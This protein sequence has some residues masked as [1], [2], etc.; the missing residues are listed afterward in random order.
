MR[1][2]G[3][4]TMSGRESRLTPVVGRD[5][6]LSAVVVLSAVVMIGRVASITSAVILTGFTATKMS[7]S[8]GLER[9]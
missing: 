6:C 1:R 5:A 3:A 9:N 7:A 8:G 2:S 4:V